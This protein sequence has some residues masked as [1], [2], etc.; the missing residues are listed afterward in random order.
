[1]ESPPTWSSTST[2]QPITLYDGGGGVS[3]VQGYRYPQQSLEIV[4]HGGK[5]T[6]QVLCRPRSRKASQNNILVKPSPSVNMNDASSYFT[7]MTDKADTVSVVSNLSELSELSTL[8]GVDEDM[9]TLKRKNGMDLPELHGPKKQSINRKQSNAKNEMLTHQRD[10]AIKEKNQIAV[11]MSKLSSQNEIITNLKQKEIFLLREKSN[12]ESELK[13]LHQNMKKILDANS[14]LRNEMSTLKLEHKKYMSQQSSNDSLESKMKQLHDVIDIL[15][16]E[17]LVYAKQIDTKN[18]E[19]KE[20]NAMM[21]NNKSEELNTKELARETKELE[22]KSQLIAT[23]EQSL[24]SYKL[25]LEVTTSSKV[26]L[27]KEIKVAR[28]ELGSVTQARDWYQQQ[29]KESQQLR[30]NAMKEAMF[31]T[32][33]NVSL[34]SSN[35]FMAVKIETLEKEVETQKTT[36]LKEKEKLV[37]KLELLD[38]DIDISHDEIKEVCKGKEVIDKTCQTESMYALEIDSNEILKYRVKELEQVNS[39]LEEGLLKSTSKQTILEGD[40]NEALIRER[41]IT[42][43]LKLLKEENVKEKITYKMIDTEME[44]LKNLNI[45]QDEKIKNMKLDLG[46]SICTTNKMKKEMLEDRKLIQVMK[47]KQLEAEEQSMRFKEIS[48]DLDS[49][50][51]ENLSLRSEL[52]KMK[53]IDNEVLQKNEEMIKLKEDFQILVVQK[54][55]N[56]AE[57]ETAKL[58]SKLLA[59]E[60]ECLLTEKGELLTLNVKLSECVQNLEAEKS[61][62][63]NINQDLNKNSDALNLKLS[64][65][66]N[67]IEEVKSEKQEIEIENR[68]LLKQFNDEK[69]DLENVIRELENVQEKMLK[70]KSRNISFDRELFEKL[71]NADRENKEK[72]KILDSNLKNAENRIKD[73]INL[74]DVY[75]RELEE[76]QETKQ[77]QSN[78][79]TLLEAKIER[80][81]KEVKNLTNEIELKDENLNTLKID[82]LEL[83]KDRG[84]LSAVLF[85]NKALQEN[86]ALL[87]QNLQTL[88]ECQG[89]VSVLEHN[90][91]KSKETIH[92]QKDHITIIT[93]ERIDIKEKLAK[94]EISLSTKQKEYIEL[95]EANKKLIENLKHDL[96]FQMKKNDELLKNIDNLKERNSELEMKY[97]KTNESLIELKNILML[98]NQKEMI[99]EEKLNIVDMSLQEKTEEFRIK[100]LEIEQKQDLHKIE[101]HNMTLQLSRLEK[102]FNERESTIHSLRG[103]KETHQKQLKQ[104]Q[105]ALKTS[106]HHIRGLRTIIEDSHNLPAPKFDEQTLS[107]LLH[108]NTPTERPKLS[109]LKLCLADLRQDVRELNLQLSDKSRGSTPT[110]RRENGT[111]TPSFLDRFQG[112]T[113]SPGQSSGTPSLNISLASSPNTS[114]EHRCNKFR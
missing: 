97:C 86:C 107:N 26:S 57:I 15:K 19:L 32:E 101:L 99:L 109:A 50:K 68:K 51:E 20:I 65:Q 43:E 102:N 73:Q 61:S 25:D 104:M 5:R 53:N 77:E 12:L 29:M 72:I 112:S 11:E 90:L 28:Q 92:E 54:S 81:E 66:A 39:E 113:L 47:S 10:I 33:A 76:V 14:V 41:R 71:Q 95:S 40:L 89:K 62:L 56:I 22:D 75:L 34:K 30:A 1:M 52:L 60:K 42:G 3:K 67:K 78:I 8:Q 93:K 2:P 111:E 6:A 105:L 35:E 16:E 45:E 114:P 48:K 44:S 91:V 37:A 110:E 103:E 9:M 21:K 88:N 38:E 96:D 49:T 87:E 31:L 63:L 17:N 4:T 74:K 13:G 23:L 106:L 83:E 18:I 27:E 79:I 80:I 64:Q 82:L 98:S 70:D 36:L 58:A 100:E 85:E 94:L 69:V 84:T 108:L 55:E 7:D 46:K 24:S 59:D